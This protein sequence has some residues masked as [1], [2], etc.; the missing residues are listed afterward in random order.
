[1]KLSTIIEKVKQFLSESLD[2]RDSG[3]EI[4]VVGVESS[5]SNWIAEAEVVERNLSL[6]GRRVFEKN[7]YLV[8]LTSNLEVIAYRQITNQDNREI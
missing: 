8:K 1:M 3:E 4:R 6:P 2:C 7:R 5:D